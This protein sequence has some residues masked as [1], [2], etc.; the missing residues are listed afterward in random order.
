MRK[1]ARLIRDAK[2]S[3]EYWT[4]AAIR[5]FVRDLLARMDA[6][7]M[8]RAELASKI[9]ASPAYVTK[10]MRGNANFTLESMTKLAMAVGGKVRVQIVEP[11]AVRYEFGNVAQTEVAGARTSLLA[12]NTVLRLPSNAANEQLFELGNVPGYTRSLPVAA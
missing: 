4:Q 9:D 2:A 12:Q 7:E 10:I 3:V 5:E 8:S 6:R 11:S 1:Y